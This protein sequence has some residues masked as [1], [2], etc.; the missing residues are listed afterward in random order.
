MQDF[1]SERCPRQTALRQS[2]SLRPLLLDGHSPTI[3]SKTD[4]VVT[5][6]G[7]QTLA[8]RVHFCLKTI[9]GVQLFRLFGTRENHGPKRHEDEHWASKKNPLLLNLRQMRWFTAMRRKHLQRRSCKQHIPHS[10]FLLSISRNSCAT[11]PA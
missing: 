4:G 2:L 6:T 3:S 8:M 5:G 1:K 7:L 11:S 10:F 9:F